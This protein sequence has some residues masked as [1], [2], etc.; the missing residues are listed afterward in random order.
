VEYRTD[1][2]GNVHC[3]IGKMSFSEA[4]LAANLQHFI[5]TIEK[6]KPAS[7]KG[8]YIKKCVVSGTMT[9]GVQVA[10]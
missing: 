7:A 2:G 1:D 10:V 5:A 4:D 8:Q 3:I 6:I 9:P